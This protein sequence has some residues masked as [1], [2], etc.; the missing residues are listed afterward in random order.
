MLPSGM[1]SRA[2]LIR[3]IDIKH[4]SSLTF[5]LQLTSQ[6]ECS[7]TLK[8][9]FEYTLYEKYRLTS[10]HKPEALAAGPTACKSFAILALNNPVFSIL[11]INRLFA[12]IILMV[13]VSSVSI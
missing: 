9:R 11:S 5:I 8:L 6:F 1:H 3:L 10:R 13:S 2:C 12:L 4:T 7:G